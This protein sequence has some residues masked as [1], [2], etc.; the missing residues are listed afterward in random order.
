MDNDRMIRNAVGA[1]IG[2]VVILCV[3]MPIFGGL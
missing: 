2:I 1:I 3:M